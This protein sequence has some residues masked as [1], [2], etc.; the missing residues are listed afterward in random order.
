MSFAQFPVDDLVAMGVDL[1][2]IESVLTAPRRS[3]E[4]VAGLGSQQQVA[5][6]YAVQDFHNDWAAGIAQLVENIG[7]F[8]DRTR[9]IAATV[10]RADESGADL[11]EGV[12]RGI[13]DPSSRA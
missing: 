11:F 9:A 7:A 10:A 4:D 2:G 6:R 1:A 3:A 8:G 13:A 5:I 12:G